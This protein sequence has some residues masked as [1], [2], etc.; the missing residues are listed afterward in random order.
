MLAIVAFRKQSTKQLFDQQSGTVNRR[1]CSRQGFSCS[2]RG[3]SVHSLLGHP[4]RWVGSRSGGTGRNSCGMLSC[5]G[6]GGVGPGVIF[7]FWGGG[8]RLDICHEPTADMRVY[9][10]PQRVKGPPSQP[11]KN[12]F[13]DFNFKSCSELSIANDRPV[14]CQHP[15]RPR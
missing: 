15:P 1:A 3:D 7:F 14:L 12:R 11:L 4:G 5:S 9:T 13:N 8:M 10:V 2:A 6:G